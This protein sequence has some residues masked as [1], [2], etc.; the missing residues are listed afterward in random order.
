MNFSGSSRSLFYAFAA[1]WQALRSIS[2]RRPLKGRE[3]KLRT[4]PLK[5][6]PDTNL[7]KRGQN[8]LPPQQTKNVCWGPR[9]RESRRDPSTPLRAGCRRY[10]RFFAACLDQ[11]G[12]VR[13]SDG[14]EDTAI[15]F[16]LRRRAHRFGIVVR[17]FYGGASFDFVHLA[18]EAKGIEASAGIGIAPA[19]IVRQQRSPTGAEANSLAGDP[20]TQVRKVVRTPEILDGHSRLQRATEIRMQAQDVVN[21]ETVGGDEQFFPGVAASGFEPR[22]VFVAGNVRVQIGR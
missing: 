1:R 12:N 4:A 17:Q 14:S 21:V 19:K 9:S 22:D 2:D 6:R 11:H 16:N 3:Q 10:S 20:L 13:D 15:T 18:D 7:H 5:R 8:A